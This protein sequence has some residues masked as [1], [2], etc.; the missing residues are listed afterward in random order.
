MVLSAA[1]AQTL[2]DGRTRST[3]YF[4]SEMYDAVVAIESLGLSVEYVTPDGG[5]PAIDP[6]SE[7]ESYWPDRATL[8]RARLRAGAIRPISAAAALSRAA[9]FSGVVVVGGQGV[10]VDVVASTDVASLLV[11]LADRPVGLICHAPALLT[12]LSSQPFLGRTVTSVSGV[13]E[14]FIETFVMGAEA[15]DRGIH[16]QLEAS[17]FTY[18]SGWPGRPFAVRDGNLVTSQNPYSGEAFG[19]LFRTALAEY[20]GGADRAP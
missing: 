8:E 3:G 16:D 6:E 4:L 7:E 9:E 13:E 10:M 1:A 20:L 15:R 2:A 17:G 14:W 5:S 18:V 11:A 19:A 12:R